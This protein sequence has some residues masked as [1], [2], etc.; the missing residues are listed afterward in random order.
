[1]SVRLAITVLWH[2]LGFID[3]PPE[4]L[5]RPVLIFAQPNVMRPERQQLIEWSY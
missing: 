5:Y 3:T 2:S 1:M 4:H